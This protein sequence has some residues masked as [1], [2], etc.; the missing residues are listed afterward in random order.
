M[1]AKLLDNPTMQRAWK[2]VYLAGAFLSVATGFLGLSAERTAKTNVDWVFI[3]IGFVATCGFPLAAVAYSR[4]IGVERF[5]RPSLDRSPL[6]WWRDPLQPLRVTLVSTAL[7][8]LGA[9]F[10]LPKADHKGVMIF[11]FYA[12]AAAG[13]FV[14]E[15]LAYWVHS[16]RID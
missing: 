15:R 1:T 14:G 5:R 11:C 12:V 8:F 4:R 6:G 7:C 13:L 3:T 16:K 2:L 10:A 9:G